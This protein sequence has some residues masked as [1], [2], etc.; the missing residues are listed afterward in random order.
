LELICPQVERE[1][2]LTE[3][4]ALDAEYCQSPQGAHQTP[5]R[6]GIGNYCFF[7]NKHVFCTT[8]RTKICYTTITHLTS[9]SK[10]VIWVAI[11]AMYKM[12]LLRGFRIVVIKGD[13]KFS[14]ISDM[15]VGL[16]TM[17]SMDWAAALQHC[18][19]I[20]QNIRFLKERFAPSAIVYPLRGCRAL[21]LSTWYCI[22]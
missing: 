16:P 5:T 7:V 1:Y 6:R 15:V 17:P 3:W 14:S 13:H 8:F 10:D 4:Q 19:L 9:R 2:S 22:L 21:W 18:G 20:K 11:E 12:Y